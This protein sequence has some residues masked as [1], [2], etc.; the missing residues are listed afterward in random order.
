M[1]SDGFR[2]V[3]KKLKLGKQK[4]EMGIATK[5]HKEHKRSFGFRVPSSSAA[6]AMEGRRSES[7]SG[8]V[9]PMVTNVDFTNTGCAVFC[10]EGAQKGTNI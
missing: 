10:R 2:W 6:A 7:D 5:E 8:G 3:R 1:G 4:A 9:P